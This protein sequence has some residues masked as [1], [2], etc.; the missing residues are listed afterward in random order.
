MEGFLD[1]GGG[2]VHIQDEAIGGVAVTLRLLA[3]AKSMTDW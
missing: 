1:V 3:L 2:A